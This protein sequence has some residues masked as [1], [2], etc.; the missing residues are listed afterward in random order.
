M[1]EDSVHQP[2]RPSFCITELG[3]GVVLGERGGAVPPGGRDGPA[4]QGGEFLVGDLVDLPCNMVG[5]PGQVI[6]SRCPG[7]LYGQGA[8]EA[9]VSA[10]GPHHHLVGASLHLPAAGFDIKIAEGVCIQRNGHPAG[11]AG[12]QRDLGKALQL[13]GRCWSG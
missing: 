3:K 7:T 9:D 11:L 10:G 8:G 4:Q 6:G 5:Q 12:R 1:P 13:Q 2:A